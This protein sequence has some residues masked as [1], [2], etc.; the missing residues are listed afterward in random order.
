MIAFTYSINDIHFYVCEHN[1]VMH[2][3]TYYSLF[4]VL[5]VGWGYLF[6]LSFGIYKFF[7]PG[8]YITV[9]KLYNPP[10]MSNKFNPQNPL[11]IRLKR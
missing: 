1:N 9:D 10:Y 5:S 2:Y 11:K 4:A 3:S 6:F 8:R 7:D